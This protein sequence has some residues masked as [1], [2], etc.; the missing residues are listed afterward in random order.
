MALVAGL[1]WC[2]ASDFVV[3]RIKLAFNVPQLSFDDA[4]VQR[5]IVG[6]IVHCF[7]VHCLSASEV[8]SAGDVGETNGSLLVDE[9]LYGRF[10]PG[11]SS[12]GWSTVGDCCF[13][14]IGWDDCC[15]S[16]I[17]WDDCCFYPFL[18]W[19]IRIFF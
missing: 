7:I 15:F 4:Q 2:Q 8:S 1:G 9:C 10:I 17:G 18:D 11:H 13:S 12:I 19:E 3:D 14:G 6:I 16:G 5:I